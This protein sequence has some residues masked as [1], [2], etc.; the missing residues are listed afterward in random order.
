MKSPAIRERVFEKIPA[1]IVWGRRPPKE[2]TQ[3]ACFFRW[4][5]WVTDQSVL[6]IAEQMDVQGS[7]FYWNMRHREGGVSAGFLLKAYAYLQDVAFPGCPID[8]RQLLVLGELRGS[9][10]DRWRSL[11]EQIRDFEKEQGADESA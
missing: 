9:D 4:V 11:V 8:V 5:A 7:A 3:L 6:E 1:H 10:E 2:E